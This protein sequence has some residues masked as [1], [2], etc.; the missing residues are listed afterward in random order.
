[1]R[2]GARAAWVLIGVVSLAGCTAVPPPAPTLDSTP[3]G[4]VITAYVARRKWHIDVG[5][6][7]ADLDPE[8]RPVQTEFGTAKYL[9]FG[10]GDRSYLLTQ[11]KN[12]PLLL[13]ALWPG[14]GIVLVTA[15]DGAP[16]LAFGGTQVIRI[17]LSPAQAHAMQSFIRATI[18]GTLAPLAPGPYAQ[19]EFY[20]ASPRYS[21]L[22]TCNTW[23]AEALRAAGQP[24]RAAGVIFASQLWHQVLRLGPPANAAPVGPQPPRSID[25][26]QGGL[27]PSWH[28][29]VVE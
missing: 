4:T 23:A 20:L 15:I 14:P 5:F 9:F 25:Q 6:A 10:F 27:V 16:A 1:M 29:T 18:A 12:A 11:H 28:T 22:H 13:R 7:S 24:V 19:S 26:L 17:V 21:A 3:A 8:L 2:A